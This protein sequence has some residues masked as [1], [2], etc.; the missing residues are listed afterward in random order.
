MKGM[1]KTVSA[2][3]ALACVTLASCHSDKEK[4]EILYPIET[5]LVGT[6]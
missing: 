6:K 2:I 4:Y 1:F 5:N 3:L